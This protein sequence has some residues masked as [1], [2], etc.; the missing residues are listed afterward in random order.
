MDITTKATVAIIRALN[1][2]F[3]QT[4]RGGRVMLTSGINNLDNETKLEITKLVQ[5][6]SAFTNDNDPHGEA[7]FGA[8]DFLGDKIFW[9]IDY[10][11]KALEY[12]SENPADASV[13]T[14]VLTI[15]LMWER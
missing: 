2:T 11:D 12:G 1:N 13:T 8:F 4:F 3:R 5:G 9:K 6:F 15:G 7:D 14:R 10:Y